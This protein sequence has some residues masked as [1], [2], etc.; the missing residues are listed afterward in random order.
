MLFPRAPG[1]AC[2]GRGE[3]PAS[4]WHAQCS[5]HRCPPPQSFLFPT[6]SPSL[7]GSDCTVWAGGCWSQRPGRLARNGDARCSSQLH[8]GAGRHT[9]IFTGPPGVHSGPR[10]ARLTHAPLAHSSPGILPYENTPWEAPHP[11]AIIHPCTF[12]H[13]RCNF[14]GTVLLAAMCGCL[15]VQP[16]THMQR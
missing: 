11:R 10:R 2:A 14:L 15:S 3:G 7:D 9:C 13:Q 1:P 4:S 12:P 16:C 6:S 5:W 8:P